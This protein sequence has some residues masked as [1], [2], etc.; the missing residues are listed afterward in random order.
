MPRRRRKVTALRTRTASRV[1]TWRST[2]ASGEA[3]T[4][5][6]LDAAKLPG[7]CCGAEFS[8]GPPGRCEALGHHALNAGIARVVGAT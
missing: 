6:K 5:F 8:T 1:Q 3:L 4:A 2:G 7:R